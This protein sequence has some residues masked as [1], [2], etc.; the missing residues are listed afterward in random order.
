MK[1]K[2]ISLVSAEAVPFVKVGGMADV[3]GALYKYLKSREKIYL[4]IPLYKQIKEKYKIETIS[5]VDVRFFESRIENGF[6]AKSK[7]FPDVYFIGHSRYF[8][9]DEIYGPGGKDYPDSAER[10]SFFSKAVLEGITTLKIDIDIFHCHD[11]HTSLLPLYLKLNY[12][13][14]FPK[15]KTLFTI[16]NLGY[17]GVFPVEKFHILGIPWQ[18]FNMEE[19]EFYGSVNFMKAGIIHSDML[20][21]VSPNYAREILTPEFGHNLDG[22]LKKYQGKLKGI[23]NGID[24]QIWNPAFDTYIAKRYRSY[25]SKIENKV[26]LQKKLSLKVDK[27]IPIFGMVSRLAEQKGIDYLIEIMGQLLKNNLQ[28]VILG[29]GEQKYRDILSLWQKKMP[30]KISLTSG[31]NE[32]LAHQIYAGSDFFLMPSRFEPCGLGQLISFK[33]GTIPIVRKVGGLADTVQNYNIN[34]EEGS[35]FVFEGGGKE[36]LAKIEEA[37]K[38]FEDKDK[39]EHLVNKVI[40]LDFSWKASVEKYLNTYNELMR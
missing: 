17:Q 15:A 4:F 6:L 40:L 7:D 16:H 22:L 11:W 34:T 30:E 33:Y 27:N 13:E 36:F 3:V 32:E 37:I 21:T 10:F 2:I 14:A 9:R 24:Y 8:E 12:K 38:L 23:L 39:M 5:P 25:K 28:I 31:F 20:N 26:F 29:D 1:K 35:G 18:Y 19:L